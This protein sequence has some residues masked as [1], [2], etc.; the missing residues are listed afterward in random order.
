MDVLYMILSHSA[1]RGSRMV[2]LGVVAQCDYGPRDFELLA[3]RLTTSCRHLVNAAVSAAVSAAE[4]A[5]IDF[6]RTIIPS[7]DIHEPC[8]A[9]MV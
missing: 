4:C 5:A 9:N 3:D 8:T 7:L 1:T 6:V 2:R